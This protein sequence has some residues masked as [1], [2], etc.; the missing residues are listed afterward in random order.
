VQW[1]SSKDWTWR[2]GYSIGDQP[3]P[4]DEVLFNILAPGVVKQHVTV[5]FTRAIGNNQELKC[6]LM[7]AFENDVTGTNPL[8]PGQRIKLTMNQWEFSV[9]YAWKF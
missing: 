7:H 6:A 9:G 2:A 1:Q 4:R 5:G 8:D 3:I